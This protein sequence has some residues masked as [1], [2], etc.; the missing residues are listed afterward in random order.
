MNSWNMYLFLLSHYSV[1]K[2]HSSGV[3]FV[4]NFQIK[5]TPDETKE[6]TKELNEPS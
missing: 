1:H 3:K 6:T 2:Q 5:E 4:R